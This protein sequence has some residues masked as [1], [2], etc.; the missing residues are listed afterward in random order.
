MNTS[1]NAFRKLLQ[2]PSAI[3]GLFV[4]FVLVVVAVY[5]MITIP[6]S[7]AIRLWRGGEEVWYQNPRFAPPA[8]IN[9]FSDRKY[10]ESFAVNTSDG[11]IVKKVTAGD[12][13]ISTVEMT[14]EFDFSYDEYP[15][16]MLFYFASAFKEK[17]PFVS[18]ELLTP[19]DRR[20]RIA[21]FAIGK[22]F[23]Y[24]FSQD[25][26][27]RAKLRAEEVIPAL[28]TM[29]DSDIPLKGKYKLLVT[30]TTFESD[31]NM[32][33]EFVLHG[34]VFGL[35]GTDHAR[36]DLTLPLLWGVPVAL[37]FGLIAS[38]G[39]SILTMII[40]AVGAWYAGWVDELIQ[41]I[42]EINLV[43]PFLAILIMIGTFYSR[44]IWVILGATI[45]LSIFT[46]A[47]KGYRAIFLQVKESMYIEAA[48]AYGASSPRIIFFYLI[49]R[50]IPLL[51]PSLVQSIPAFVFLEASLAVIGLGDPVLPT[52]G[53]IIQ[54]AQSNGA[55]Y[56]GYYYWVLEPA[57]L[58]MITGL[59]FAVLGFA[60]DR[61][62]N[63]KLRDI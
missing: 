46:G 25:E 37:A 36:R 10:S 49:P 63:P 24:R 56:K 26:K 15:Q 27:L 7:E 62:F 13:G 34:Q 57:I 23:T 12:G 21:N 35:A 42:T 30:G 9:Y 22:E 53:K 59:A 16:E 54:D 3:A 11:Q 44:S 45:L 4:V 39:T 43:L 50:M 5:A 33:L 51:I 61:I 31:S 55:L 60:L 20:I 58:L 41:R 29:P 19:D 17:Q 2:F 14:Y 6:Y 47:I 28:F 18:I 40:A 8:W 48:R 38:V 32:D 52:W 1:R